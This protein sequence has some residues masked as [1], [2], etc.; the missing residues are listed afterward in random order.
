MIDEFNQPKGKRA[1]KMKRR[2][3]Y[4][5]VEKVVDRRER[6]SAVEYLIRWKGFSQDEDTWQPLSH[7]RGISK[8]VEKF[9]KGSKLVED[10][11]ETHGHST[12]PRE[13]ILM[14]LNQTDNYEIG[15]PCSGPVSEEGSPNEVGE[16]QMFPLIGQINEESNEF[17]PIDLNENQLVEPDFM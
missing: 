17:I 9:N 8:L 16:R 1:R 12:L 2:V 10:R 6:R 11:P 3:K 13:D 5:E 14:E 4:Y 15:G 7:L